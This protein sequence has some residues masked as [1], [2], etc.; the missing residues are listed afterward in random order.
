MMLSEGQ[1][2]GYKRATLMLD[3]LPRAKAMPGDR[4][5]DADWFHTALIAK[6]IAPCIPSKSN[7]K[8]PIPHD[9]TLYRPATSHRE[10]IRPRSK[11]G[12]A[13]TPATITVHTPYMSAIC[14]AAAVIF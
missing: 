12:G 8:V 3:A 5:Y 4:G 2:S 1:I 13:S 11:N 7:R 14:I 6:G 9:W 10:H